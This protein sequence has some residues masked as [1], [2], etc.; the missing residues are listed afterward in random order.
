[1][2]TSRYMTSVKNVPAIFQKIIEGTAPDKFTLT[3]LK[4]IGFKSSNDQ[5]IIP[6][7]KDLAFLSPDG[8]P[9]KRYLDYRDKSS[10]RQVLGGALRETYED[11]FH[12]NEHPT[13]GDRQAVIGRFKSVHNVTDRVAEQQAVTFFALLKLADIVTPAKQ[14]P[15]IAPASVER[16]KEKADSTR[17]PQEL[18]AIPFAGLRYNIESPL[19]ASKAVEVFDA[20][21]KSLKEHLLDD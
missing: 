16:E 17:V 8:I 9:T 19:P 15:K 2:L 1:M 12:I 18:S 21:F 14:P 5:G 10:S 13:E 6:L 4:G 7:L 3:H 11:L 20:I